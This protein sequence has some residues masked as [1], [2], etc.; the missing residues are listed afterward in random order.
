MV[1]NIRNDRVHITSFKKLID[2][3][4]Y[5]IVYNVVVSGPDKLHPKVILFDVIGSI[6]G[7]DG[8]Y[9]DFTLGFKLLIGGHHIELVTAY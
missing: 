8:T 7:S 2:G 9:Y 5:K 3:L 6:T 1:C 4:D